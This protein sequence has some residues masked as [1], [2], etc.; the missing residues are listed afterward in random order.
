[1][2]RYTLF[3]SRAHFHIFYDKCIAGIT[4]HARTH[5]SQKQWEKIHALVPITVKKSR[6]IH[7][8]KTEVR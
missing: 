8:K 5:G 4:V 3:V 7:K 2:P 6:E 1:M